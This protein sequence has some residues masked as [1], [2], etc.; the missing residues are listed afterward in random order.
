MKDLVELVSELPSSYEFQLFKKEIR[1]AEE[2]IGY[3]ESGR[4]A[5]AIFVEENPV[6]SQTVYMDIIYPG[7]L[8]G[9]PIKKQDAFSD[10]KYIA[11]ENSTV[12]L[13]TSSRF[14]WHYQR[15]MDSGKLQALLIDYSEAKR[16]G[17]GER[18]RELILKKGISRLAAS[19]EHLANKQEGSGSV[20]L[21]VTMDDLAAMSLLARENVCYLINDALRVRRGI[22]PKH[23]PLHKPATFEPLSRLV[24]SKGKRAIYIDMA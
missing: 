12:K 13:S 3:V 21:D 23:F 16:N 5:E 18:L 6:S 1:F 9:L 2:L 20:V 17:L 11:L 22:Q 7:Q 14:I 15:T 4:L 10:L 24:E 8:I 19:I